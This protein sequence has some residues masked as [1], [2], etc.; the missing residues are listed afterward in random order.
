MTDHYYYRV[1][2]A[3]GW[4]LLRFKRDEFSFIGAPMQPSGTEKIQLWRTSLGIGMGRRIEGWA[5]DG[6]IAYSLHPSGTVEYSSSV[7]TGS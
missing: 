5:L 7:D 3:G 4:D 1:F 6:R 2:A